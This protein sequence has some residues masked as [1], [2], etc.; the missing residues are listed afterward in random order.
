MT[1]EEAYKKTKA[2]TDRILNDFVDNLRENTGQSWSL[3]ELATLTSMDYEI[4]KE[5]RLAFYIE[6]KIRTHAKGHYSQEK[7]PLSKYTWAYTFSNRNDIKSYYLICWSDN[8]GIVDLEKTDEIREMVARY[9]RGTQTDLYAMYKIEDFKELPK[10]W[11]KVKKY[12][13]IP[14]QNI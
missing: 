3:R 10:L 7:V 11:E 2:K 5:G 4:Y 8:I 6:A 9:D 14:S 13:D 1:S 12:I